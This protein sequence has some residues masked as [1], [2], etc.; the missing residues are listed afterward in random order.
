MAQPQSFT[1]TAFCR[2]AD[3]KG[4][5]WIAAYKSP[6]NITDADE[7]GLCSV[8]SDAVADC[9]QT[10][11]YAEADVVCVGVVRGTVDVIQWDDF[12]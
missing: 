5:T 1:Y 6:F 3:G 7:S 8:I 4:T 11:G 9:A 12:A 10:W 2:Q